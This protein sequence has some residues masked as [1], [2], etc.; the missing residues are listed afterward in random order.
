MALAAGDDFGAL[1]DGIADVLLDLRHRGFVD[2]RT[3]HHAGIGAAANLEAAHFLGQPGGERVVNPVLNQDAI[4]AYA[5]LA[6][7]AVLRGDGALDSGIEIGVV[8]D[9]E[10]GVAAELHRNLLDRVGALLDQHAPNFGRTGKGEL[11]HQRVRRQLGPDGGGLSGDDVEH[12]GGDAGPL[13]QR[14]HRQCRQRRVVRGLDHYRAAHRQ[15]RSGLA[16]DHRSREIPRRDG[17]A[18]ADGL[19]DD[20]EPAVGGDGGDHVAVDALRFFAEPFDERGGKA[21]LAP[22]FSDRLAL[23]GGEDQREIVLVGEH[24]FVP[25]AHDGGALLGRLRAPDEER[26]LSGVHGTARFRRAHARDGADDFA[27]GRIFDG[28]G[29]AVIRGE[30]FAVHQTFVAQ[31]RRVLEIQHSDAPTFTCRDQTSGEIRFA[32]AAYSSDPQ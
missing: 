1:G 18:H 8:E 11:A 19:L 23:F 3:L 31:Q 28:D 7:V 4:G 30:P 21:D 29:R 22:S 24:Q 5:G 17:R 20:D 13:G 6:A 2:Q 27:V 16:A 14:G 15:C 25:A 32:S 10:R 9:D 26:F 12:A